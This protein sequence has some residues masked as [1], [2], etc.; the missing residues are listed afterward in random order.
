MSYL[1]LVRYPNLIIIIITQMLVF[2]CI[3]EN[4]ILNVFYCFIVA[5]ATALMAAAGNVINDIYDI[6]ADK[7]NKPYQLIIDKSISK[8]NAIRF[9]HILN[10][11]SL[12]LTYWVCFQY[13]NYWPSGL[14]WFI[15]ITLYFYSSSF[16]KVALIGNLVVAI[17]SASSIIM[18][19][20]F[21]K[22]MNA[23]VIFYFSFACLIS[24]IR[25][26]IKDMEDVEGDKEIDAN[27]FPI[28][29][30]MKRS[31]GL[32]Y[33]LILT[34][35]LSLLYFVPQIENIYYSSLISAVVVIGLFIVGIKTKN[36]TLSAHFHKISSLLKLIMI[37]GILTM[38]MNLI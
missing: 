2:A 35:F 14:A 32:I 28:K 10:F 19:A 21:E 23:F 30:G 25:E 22:E 26:L 38:L 29:Y 6:E 9:Y 24:W 16:K 37:V 4:P 3:F 11:I 34:S 1:L 17:L 12:A 15:I 33:G 7:I 18:I 36:A 13:D 27:T 31:K 5:I 8:G 20:L